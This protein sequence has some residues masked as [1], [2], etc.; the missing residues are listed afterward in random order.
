M[1][2]GFFIA[3]LGGLVAKSQVDR[4]RN[5]AYRDALARKRAIQRQQSIERYGEPPKGK[6]R[7]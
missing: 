1:I 7:R 3:I 2:E 5:K 6:R 4:R